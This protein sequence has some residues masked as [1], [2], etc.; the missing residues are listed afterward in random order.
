MGAG[1]RRVDK[2][3]RASGSGEEGESNPRQT[4]ESES[5]SEVSMRRETKTGLRRKNAPRAMQRR[6]VKEAERC[7]N[8]RLE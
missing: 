3:S 1:D 7:R 2:G 8:G 5:N 4:L 6:S